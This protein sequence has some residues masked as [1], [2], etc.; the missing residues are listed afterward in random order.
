MSEISEGVEEGTETRE[1]EGDVQG[2]FLTQVS[3]HIPLC[4]HPHINTHTH[5]HTHIKCT[6]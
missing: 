2:V 6:K 5:T 4:P 3:K 1:D